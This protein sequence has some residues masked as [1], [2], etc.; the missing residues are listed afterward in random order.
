MSHDDDDVLELSAVAADERALEQLR[1]PLPVAGDDRALVLLR[2]LLDDVSADLPSA[3][4]APLP[5][6]LAPATRSRRLVGRSAAASAAAGL[7]LGLGGVAAAST[8]APVGAPLHGLGS[9]LRGAAGQDVDTS[10]APAAAAP[11]RTPTRAAR[12]APT[13]V[14]SDL[15][16]RRRPP[17]TVADAAR[18]GEA[19]AAVTRLLDQAQAALDAGRTAQAAERL[20]RAEVR[21]ADV[22][23][24]DVPALRTRVD[25][26]RTA[27]AAA[28]PGRQDPA[29]T[30]PG[31][32]Q[33]KSGS[34]GSRE[35][36]TPDDAE[37]SRGGATGRTK[38]P[39]APTAGHAERLDHAQVRPQ[40]R[41]AA[42]RP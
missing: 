36:A 29:A 35:R 9:V 41:R 10:A 30:E 8:L 2:A 24:S 40:G 1:L 4:P 28:G 21:L 5:L 37:T 15:L 39:A 26:L 19:A 33:H 18:G 34:G 6:R 32:P 38:G 25:R 13:G 16:T 7:V 20:D 42:A 23:A 12:P 31:H 11:H 3:A 17:S 14:S 22:A 27:L